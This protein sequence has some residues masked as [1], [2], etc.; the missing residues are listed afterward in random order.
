MSKFN[1]KQ[2]YACEKPEMVRS[3]MVIATMQ[4]LQEKARVH[5]CMAMNLPWVWTSK[6][7]TAATDGFYL[8]FNEQFFRS[9]PNHFQRAFLVAHEVSHVILQHPQR[10]KAYMDRGYVRTVGND[11]IPFVGSFYNQDADAVINADLIAHGLEMIPAGILRGDVNR[12]MFV[13]DVYLTRDWNFVE[14]PKNDES[15]PPTPKPQDGDDQDGDDQDGDQSGG[16]DTDDDNNMLSDLPVNVAPSDDDGGDGG[17]D[18]NVDGGEGGDGESSNQPVDESDPLDGST[19]EGHDTHLVPQYDGESEADISAQAKADAEI[20]ERNIDNALD[21]L[22]SASEREGHN[23]I[24]T[25]DS[26]ANSSGRA[27]VL[28]ASSVDWRSALCDRVTTLS[29]GEESTWARINRR[30][31]INTGVISPSKRGTFN[32]IGITIDVSWSC[33]QYADVVDKFINE[34]ASLVDTLAPKSG[35]VLIQ[36][37]YEV[38]SVDEPTTGAEL[39][40]VDIRDGGGTYMAASVEWLE[41]NGIDCDV[42]LI[43]TDGEMGDEDYRICAESGAILVLVRHP[44][45]YERKQIANCGI[46]FIVASDDPLAA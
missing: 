15:T 3:R 43:F 12:D 41:Q 11:R 25:S 39:L 32:R 13:D 40:D 10:G 6:I 24:T 19:S 35:A 17:D 1:A 2:L 28:N 44:Q 46:D 37:G 31:Y 21:D 42:H 27:K 4:Y 38:E 34:A 45:W 29:A 5:Y 22:E 30:R 9:L 8:Y 26:I 18:G 7:P 16:D 23:Q 33:L 14:D 36:C 20:I